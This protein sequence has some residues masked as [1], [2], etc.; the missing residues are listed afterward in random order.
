MTA[1]PRSFGHNE[2]E[3]GQDWRCHSALAGIARVERTRD[4][5]AIRMPTI[6]VLLVD[7][8]R[9]ARRDNIV[10]DANALSF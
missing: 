5:C 8:S 1:W 7:L 2:H 6:N 4:G 3:T 10:D 9:I